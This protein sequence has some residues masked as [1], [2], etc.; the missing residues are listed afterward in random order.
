MKGK[1][2]LHSQ[3]K[4]AGD[5]PK[6][7]RELVE[8]LNRGDKH[9]TLL[10]VTGSGKTFT[11]SNV[12]EQVQRPTLVISPNKTLA[13]QLYSEF[14]AFFPEN[15]VEYFISYYDYYQPEAYI[16]RTDTYIEKDFS[17]N[18]EIDRLRLKATSA[19]IEERRDVIIVASV[20][21]IYSI[22]KK[23]DFMELILPLNVGMN[24]SR[25][26]LIY[27]L[28]DLHY[29]RNDVDFQRGSFRVRGD[30][31]DVIPAYE[32]KIG[33]R[34]ELF[35]DEI[36]SISYIDAFSGKSISKLDYIVIYPSKLFVTS[37]NKLILAMNR[38]KDELHERLKE[39]RE[40]GKL[41][42]AQRLEQRTLFDLEM[43]R[44]VG[45][46]S[47]IENYSMHL[48]GR[49][50]GERPH[51][52][53]DYFPEDYLLVIDESHI[54][55][56]QIRGMYNGDRARKTTLVEHGF[57]LPSA[58]EN[59]PLKFDEF[60]SLI[61]QVIFVSAT[62]GDYE[63]E[64]C[65]GVVVEQVIR[66]TGLLDP[67]IEVRPTKNQIDDLT[68]EIRKRV[69]NGN[70]V[71]V[72]TLTKR[73]AE[74]LAEFL[75]NID[76]KVD[77]IH[78]DIDALNRVDI[79]RRLRLG[80]TD[81]LIGVNLLREG[82]DLPEVSLV[83]VLDA[84]KEG[85]LRSERSLL[86]VAGRTAR[87]V[88]GLVILYAD[89]ITNSMQKVINETNRRRKLQEEYNKKHNIIPKTVYKS[90]DEILS[91]TSVADI[92]QSRNKQKQEA[93]LKSQLKAI[94]PI[95]EM[96][97]HSNRQKIIAQLT[98]Q[99]KIAASELNFEL[100]AR[101][102]DEIELLKKEEAKV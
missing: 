15:A 97:N 1:F 4:P 7:I 81:V 45:Y 29:T 55:I 41:V 2:V 11:I 12:I 53:F 42:E 10:G 8:G 89:K 30:Y 57:R 71:L 24:I 3:Y 85:F 65:G 82:L 56:P 19:L 76:I 72:T 73:M 39:L 74:D 43:M 92:S 23:E 87:N 16:P 50:F 21:C 22:G 95:L 69:A 58:L 88:D 99:M 32:N 52:I 51:C 101:L 63:L 77:Y 34:I 94:D 33:V 83:A 79:I 102:R 64:K 14:K 90:K 9:Q 18:D 27:K 6:A 80:E 47:G 66:P 26:Q 17:I 67:R 38:I 60:E 37:E 68:G 70:R 28:A 75:N 96:L 36:E 54:T 84:D 49:D 93:M 59:R 31:I 48:S 91:S 62:P 44:E 98:E 40:E 25:K 61:N 86:Q 20:S 78:S 13:A 35:G 100:A 5:Q 46:C